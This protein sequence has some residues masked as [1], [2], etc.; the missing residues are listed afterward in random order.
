MFTKDL[1][2]AARSLAKSP[3]FLVTA[4]LTIAL[5]IGASTAIFSVTN[6]VLLR[7]LPYKDPERLII[8]CGDMRKR[9]VKDFPFSNAEYFDLR[10]AAKNSFEDFTGVFTFRG[11]VLRGDGTPEQVHIGIV[12][13][14]FFRL[15]GAKIHA[16]RDFEDGDGQPQRASGAA[17]ATPAQALPTIA[18]LSYEY[19]Q[20]RFGGDTAILGQS[21]KAAGGDAGPQIVGVLAPRFELLFPPDAN[22]E[23]QPDIWIAGR[24]AYDAANR[25]NVSLQVVGRL[26]PGVTLDRAQADA[27]A[28]SQDQQ[29]QFTILRTSD[30]HVRLV[31][32]Q[33]HLIAE[34]TPAILALMGAVVFL[35]LIACSNVAN[36]LLV[37]A[38]LRERELAVRTALGGSRW[39]LVR[40]MLAEAL[41]LSSLGTVLG[42]ALAWIGIHE[43]LVIAPANLPRLDTIRIDPVVVAFT[44]L[45]GLAAAAIFGVVP[46]LRASR[47]DIMHVLRSSGRTAGLGGGRLLRNSVVIVE[48]ALSFVLLIGSG[49][50][51]RSF[52]ELQR[53]NPGFD[54]HR[55]LT[56]LLVG[57]RGG[58]APEQRAA[59]QREI[60]QG[61]SQLGGVESVT[62]AFP[63]PLA[64]GFNPVRWGLEPALAD[65][66][67]FQAADL[68]IVLPGYFEAMH[69]PLIEGRT[70]TEADNAPTRKVVIIDRS[71]A[72]KAFP[73]QSAVGKRILERAATPEAEWAEVIGVVGHQREESLATPGREQIYF[74]DG[75]FGH[76]VANYWGIRTTGD[77]AK[78]G[79]AV[80]A[81]M[82]KIVPQSVITDLQ[83]MD[84]LVDKAQAGTR[85][86]L[87]LIGVFAVIAALLAGVGLYGVLATVVRQRSPE[88]GVR[89]A[90]GAAPSSV[91]RLMIGQGLRLSAAGIGLGLLAALGLTRVMIS[92][93]V[94]VKA[95]DPVTYA[96]MV[97]I[98]LMIAALASWIPARRAA[99]LDPTRALRDE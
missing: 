95:T 99:T 4:V 24:L 40:Q 80:R 12:T 92:M 89:M 11:P 96:A 20:R 61:L 36:L 3:V 49:L 73:N 90:L 33:Q 18:I 22:L 15:M 85:F 27:D 68:Q 29:R 32:M 46:A 74:V 26:K 72:A 41:L 54:S 47:P 66:S 48:V 79:E 16:G 84:V 43:L 1:L 17:N 52:L 60:Q 42:L 2:Y 70:F 77:P 13:T 5:G 65:P 83:P 64:G 25:N 50:M 53:I 78:Y 39:S 8:A 45:A 98:F 93:L 14:N 94:G 44:A 88:I 82:A 86:S 21:I 23:R 9:N 69:V 7:P 58:R 37:R 62:A 59:F 51:F 55:L 56:F 6:A 38:S 97:A 30:W 81:A 35:L 31:P 87:L 34:V 91:F 28:F 67:K 63:F 57:G 75:F 19:W 71:L 10:E 76:G